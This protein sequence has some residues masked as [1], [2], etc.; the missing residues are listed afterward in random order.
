MTESETKAHAL[1]AARPMTRFDLQ[2][3]LHLSQQQTGL[4]L[5]A[6][7]AIVVGAERSGKGRSAP[8]YGFK[9][10]AE[11]EAPAPIGRVSS[12]WDLGLA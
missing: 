5:K 9:P 2:I 11:F 6:I 3:K 1:L 12:V 7:G 8:L 4:I 10:Q